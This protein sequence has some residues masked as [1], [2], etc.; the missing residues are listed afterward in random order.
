MSLTWPNFIVGPWFYPKRRLPDWA[1][2]LTG[3]FDPQVADILPELAKRNDID[4]TRAKT[5][6]G[7]QPHTSESAI[8]EAAESLKRHG[9]A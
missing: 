5:V 2:Y 9:L 4:R 6:L 1:P 8:L 7:W 3:L